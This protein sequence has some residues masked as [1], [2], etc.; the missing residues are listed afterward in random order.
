MAIGGSIRFGENTLLNSRT[1]ESI[2]RQRE[3]GISGNGERS[4]TTQGLLGRGGNGNHCISRKGG[5]RVR[6]K[7]VSEDWSRERGGL[8]RSVKGM[9]G[10]GKIK[11]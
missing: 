2:Q 6:T 5:L 1:M 3:R 11:T 10:E 9:P 8:G 7:V 4:L